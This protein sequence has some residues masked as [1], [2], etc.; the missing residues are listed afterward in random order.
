MP[1]QDSWFGACNPGTAFPSRA[2]AIWTPIR[3]RRMNPADFA[4]YF[5]RIPG[6]GV[7]M[8]LQ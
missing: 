1:P 7:V 5:A 6:N 2:G 3:W 8:A 4:S